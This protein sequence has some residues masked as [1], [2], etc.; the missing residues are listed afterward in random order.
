M[1]VMLF[2]PPNWTPS[3]PHLAL[4]SL[5]AY[6]RRAG[7]EVIQRDL[8]AEVFEHVLTRDF[9]WRSVER[10]RSL[11]PRPKAPPLGLV[12]WGLEQGPA[13]AEAVTAAKA[14]IRSPSFYDGT[15]SRPAFETVLAALQLA[16]LPYYPSR[17]DLQTYVSAY[18]PD[19]SRGILRA[20]DD[21]DRNMFIEIFE[22][23]VL[24]DVLRENPEVVGIS[25]P[26]V[27]Q[28]IAA[29]TLARV[30]K[31]GGVRS[32]LTIG[33]PMVSIWREQLANVPDIFTLFDSAVVFDGEEPLRRLTEAVAGR[34]ALEEVPN[35]IYRHGAVVKVN[36]RKE[37]ARIAELPPPDFDG[38]PLDCYLAPELALPLA[39]TRGCYF[40]R[41]AFCNVGY[42]E[43]EAFSQQRGDALLDQMLTLTQRYGSRRVFFVDEAMTPRLVRHVAPRLAERGAPLRWAGCMRFERILDREFLELARAG[44]CCMILF[45][46]ESASQRVMDFMVKG[47]HLEHIRRILQESHDAGIWNHTF[48]FFGFPGETIEDAQETVNFVFRH[49]DLINSASMGTFLLERYAP[50]Y[51]YPNAF[52]ITRVIERPEADLAFYF[53]YEVASGMDAATAELIVSRLEERLPRKEFPQFYVSDVYRFLYAAH[54]SEQGLPMPPW[55]EQSVGI[56]AP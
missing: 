43:P 37:Q 55:I 45:G 20:V 49:G 50:A 3:M 38:L 7:I 6:L 48:F 15:I 35:L 44:G 2:F 10:L 41:C 1:K 17:L 5:T 47:T 27:N 36:R 14:V 51:M 24:P 31:R 4:P 13:V 46:L 9:A 23:M 22:E 18:R 21:R 26:C 8:N 25:I 11:R 56:A 52:G 29:M 54:L 42:G 30:L 19:S 53:D 32:H 40:G 16:S 33:G 28:I 39:M 12:R 34:G